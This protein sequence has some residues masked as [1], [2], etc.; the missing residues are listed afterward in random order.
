MNVE[1]PSRIK[2]TEAREIGRSDDN[3][4]TIKITHLEIAIN[5]EIEA[6]VIWL[7]SFH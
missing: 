3:G 5:C 6:W 7:Y 2:K 4:T 1:H